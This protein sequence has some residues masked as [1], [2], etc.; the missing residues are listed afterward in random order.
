[1]ARSTGFMATL[2][3]LTQKTV[4]QEVK[5]PRRIFWPA[6]KNNIASAS[7]CEFHAGFL[8][9]KHYARNTGSLRG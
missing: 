5:L 9:L 7:A 4:W 1:M 6:Q 8:A 2:V 3:L